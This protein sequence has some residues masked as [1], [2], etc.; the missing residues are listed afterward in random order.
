MILSLGG[1][2]F[3]HEGGDIN[4]HTIKKHVG[5]ENAELKNRTFKEKRQDISSFPNT[6]IAEQA[7]ADTII[8]NKMNIDNWLKNPNLSKLE[9][10]ST[11]P[12]SQ[13]TGTLYNKFSD[14]FT[15]VTNTK[16]VI[17]KDSKFPE[18]YS[19]LTAFPIK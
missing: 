18:G 9:F 6:A 10:N 15:N 13:F 12:S 19:I 3:K 4:G 16:V 14:Q 7:I 5:W 8:Q 17:I 1:N 11:S 2:L